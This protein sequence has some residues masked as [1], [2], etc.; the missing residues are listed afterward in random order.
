MSCSLYT[1]PSGLVNGSKFTCLAGVPGKGGCAAEDC[2]GL[3]GCS[4]CGCSSPTVSRS[5]PRN[6]D[7]DAWPLRKSA[8]LGLD[9]T[10]PGG[11]LLLLLLF[12]RFSC[13]RLACCA[14]A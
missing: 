12:A 3:A 9:M 7:V 11:S 8:E 13:P 5:D 10:T 14:A 1:S 2:L 6:D 4:C